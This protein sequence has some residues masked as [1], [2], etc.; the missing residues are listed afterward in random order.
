MSSKK[1]LIFRW[2]LGLASI[3]YLLTLIDFDEFF[4]ALSKAHTSWILTSIFVVFFDRFLMAFKWNL[5]LKAQGIF[6]SLWEVIRAYLV[7][8][9]YGLV[10]P[11]S[12]GSDVVRLGSLSVGGGA[13]EKV[14]ASIVVEK[15]L[16]MMALFLLVLLSVLG[17]VWTATLQHWRYFMIALALFLVGAL[18]FFLSFKILPIQRLI[19]AKG[20]FSKKIARVI[21]AYHQFQNHKRAMGLFFALSFIEQF[22][23]VVGNFCLARAFELPG[24]FF[25]YLMVIPIIFTVARIPISVDAVGILEALYLFLLPLVGISK[26]DAFLLGLV[27]RVVNTL[28]LLPGGLLYHSVK[29]PVR[30][31]VNQSA[32]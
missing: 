31:M 1:S 7:G 11:T 32:T 23:P 10:L 14:A 22:M 28:C 15:I 2:G 18:A 24:S 16:A 19:K 6:V 9:F 27:G 5:L 8:S 30:E 21:L 17:L 13:R 4:S 3:V 26:T 20:H 12:L 29:N 25:S